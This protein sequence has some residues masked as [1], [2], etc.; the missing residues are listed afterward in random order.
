MKKVIKC[1]IGVLLIGLMSA[2]SVGQYNSNSVKTMDFTPNVVRLEMTLNDFILLGEVRVDVSYRTYLSAFNV[3]ETINGQDYN[4]RVS[5][6]VNFT[7]ARAVKLSKPIQRATYKV[8]EL[9]P[10]A[11][12]YVPVFTEKQIDGLFLGRHT[13]EAV[14]FKA[15]KQKKIVQ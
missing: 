10:D 15:Y 1:L 6:R 14:T 12:Y 11:D 8:I 7:G 13:K 4:R 9:F 3:F 5:N 2:C